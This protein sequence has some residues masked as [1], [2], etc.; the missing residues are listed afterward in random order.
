MNGRET[1]PRCHR[2][3][4]KTA[5]ETA[6]QFDTT[7]SRIRTKIVMTSPCT[8]SKIDF[9]RDEGSIVTAKRQKTGVERIVS[10]PTQQTG[11]HTPLYFATL[12]PG[13]E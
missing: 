1:R 6:R 5:D 4:G 7:I 9:R 2:R 8:E 11:L 3:G 10:S 12:P 13:S